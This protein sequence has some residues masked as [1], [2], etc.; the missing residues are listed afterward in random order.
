MS[1]VC[2]VQSHHGYPVDADRLW[3]VAADWDALAE[4]NRGMVAQ[5]GLPGGRFR[6]G[7]KLAIEVSGFG[8]MPRQPYEIEILEC[9][10]A[11]RVMVSRERGAGIRAWNHRMWVETCPQGEGSRLH[12][13]IEI[14]AGPMTPA[15][16]L[17][18]R[19]LYRR[20]HPRRMRMLGVAG[21]A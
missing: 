20:R 9:D 17:W 3:A 18:A 13:R 7:Q 4:A 14:D 16:A 1:R 8:V 15:F 10:D 12:D 6:S 19:V 5:Y 2:V 21:R 11:A